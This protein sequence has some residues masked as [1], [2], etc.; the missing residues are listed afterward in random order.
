MYSKVTSNL[1]SASHNQEDMP[2]PMQCNNQTAALCV[3][4][5]LHNVLPHDMEAVNACLELIYFLNR[6]KKIQIV[7]FVLQADSSRDMPQT[8]GNSPYL[9]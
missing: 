1:V 7:I 5:H 6:D 8:H 9:C 3:A 2:A 4:I